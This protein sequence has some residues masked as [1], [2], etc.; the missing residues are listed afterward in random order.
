ML[1]VHPSARL[2]GMEPADLGVV[3]KRARV[4]GKVGSDPAPPPLPRRIRPQ[5]LREK[6]A[7]QR[8]AAAAAVSRAVDVAGEGEGAGGE[9]GV[10]GVFARLWG[11]VTRR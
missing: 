9:G 8:A 2:R 5:T 3:G 6:Q 1:R 10:R 4:G 11:F 7:M